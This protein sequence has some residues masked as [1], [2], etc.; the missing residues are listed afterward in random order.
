MSIETVEIDLPTG[1]KVIEIRQGPAGE[2]GGGSAIDILTG[3]APT[4]S[5]A[6]AQNVWV[7]S[8]ASVN[9]TAGTW[10][11]QAFWHGS[12]ASASA[13]NVR[14]AASANWTD[15]NGRRI[16]TFTGSTAVTS[17]T[18][19][20]GG[21]SSAANFGTGGQLAGELIAIVKMTGNGTLSMQMTNTAGTGTVT[22]FAGSHIVAT[23]L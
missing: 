2:G 4:D 23:R 3:T 12:N 18:Y 10:R 15:T 7:D 9:L 21:T 8:G 1:I 20:T 16:A 17:L 6:T 11:V 19:V 5:T 13:S 22:C 14:L